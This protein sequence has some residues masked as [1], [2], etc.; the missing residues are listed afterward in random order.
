MTLT[1]LSWCHTGFT[2]SSNAGPTCAPHPKH[3]QQN[4]LTSWTRDKKKSQC[5]RNEIDR[6]SISDQNLKTAISSKPSR[7][8]RPSPFAIVLQL[9]LEVWI[10]PLKGTNFLPPPWI[11]MCDND[12]CHMCETACRN[13]LNPSSITADNN[14]CLHFNRKR[15]TLPG[16]EG[17]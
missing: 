10:I 14:E 15:R 12:F 8:E 7:L 9:W 6:R 1:T 3:L 11:L 16:G 2:G 13:K 5:K 17:L 4:P